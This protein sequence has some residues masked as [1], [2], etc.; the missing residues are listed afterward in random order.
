MKIRQ[1]SGMDAAV[2][3]CLLHDLLAELAG[4]APDKKR[5]DGLVEVARDLMESDALVWGLLAL[6]DQERALG[7]VMLNECAA[8][9]AGGRFGEITELYVIPEQRGSGVGAGLIRAAERFAAERGWPRLEVGAP[10]V[11]RWQA[12]VAFYLRSGFDEVGPR[13]RRVL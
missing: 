5:L 9:Y 10:D 6:D 3:G 1:A 8:T 13:L 2:V 11:P 4:V 7:V 12:T